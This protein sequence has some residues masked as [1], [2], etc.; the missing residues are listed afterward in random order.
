MA[1]FALSALLVV[2]CSTRFF[3]WTCC[4]SGLK[5]DVTVRAN[6]RF[7]VDVGL[8]PGYADS[9]RS[10]LDKNPNSALPS[11]FTPG[12]S[13]L[14][15]VH[16]DDDAIDLVI[17]LEGGFASNTTDPTLATNF[18]IPLS[19]LSRYLG[20]AATVD[21]LRSLSIETA[22]DIYKKQFLTGGVTSFTSIQVK[23][24]YLDLATFV[25]AKLAA[26]WFQVAIGKIDNGPVTREAILGPEIVRRI[27]AADPDLL[28]ETANCEAAKYF[29][30][31]STLRGLT[32]GLMRR[33][34]TFSPATLKGICPDLQASPG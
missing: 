4:V 5:C 26:E 14:Q 34:R 10:F 27:N 29:Q 31:H 8:V 9:L 11:S 32:T 28:I 13:G 7:L 16:T 15:N 6:L 21:D 22:R 3:E 2:V 30:S 12:V 23:A 1:L 17:R 24:A 25:G 20:T 19:A 18:G 33:L